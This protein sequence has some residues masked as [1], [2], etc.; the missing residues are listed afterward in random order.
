MSSTSSTSTIP[1]LGNLTDM[2]QRFLGIQ[3]AQTLK[4]EN[5]TA[6]AIARLTNTRGNIGRILA[7]WEPNVAAAGKDLVNQYDPQEHDNALRA[8]RH[9]LDVSLSS[10]RWDDGRVRA[11]MPLSPLL[12][13]D[14]DP[15]TVYRDAGRTVVEGLWVGDRMA[16]VRARI[17]ATVRAWE[18]AHPVARVLVPL[19]TPKAVPAPRDD[20]NL[21]RAMKENVELSGWRDTLVR[22]D[23]EAWLAFASALSVDEQL[24]SMTS[25]VCLHLHIALLKML[26]VRDSAGSRLPVLY[27]LAIDGD[28]RN[29]VAARG[30]YGTYAFWRDRPEQSLALVANEEVDKLAESFP[31]LRASLEAPASDVRARAWTTIHFDGKQTSKRRENFRLE[32]ERALESATPEIKVRELVTSCLVKVFGRSASSV[33][34]KTKQYL[35]TTGIGAGIVGPTW[36]TSHK[37]Y[38]LDERGLTLLARLHAARPL[39]TIKSSEEDRRSVPAFLDDIFTRF[40]MIVTDEREVVQRARAD[41]PE[42]AKSLWRLMPSA[43][44]ML[45]NH[46][47]LDRKLDALRLVRRY[48]DA[49]AVIHIAGG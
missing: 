35:R 9:V 41:A 32:L 7:L 45:R 24:E 1:T 49:S 12:V 47:Q 14:K 37:R 3:Q 39:E 30:A 29:P 21:A 26:A 11:L 28:D 8:L 23:W 19:A 34:D 13:T 10:L 38:L 42:H 2:L 5:V 43:D 31:E 20:A 25:L 40:G 16:P 44:A 48:S 4:P 46:Q 6:D 15:G 17:E 27:F 36:G 33:T 22:E 18:H